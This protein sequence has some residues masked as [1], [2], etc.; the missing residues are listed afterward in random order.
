MR[1]A[2]AWAAG[3]VALVR[4][5]L[6]A[7]SAAV[8]GLPSAKRRSGRSVTSQLPSPSAAREA[9]SCGTTGSPPPP[10]P[11]PPPPGQP[12]TVHDLAAITGGTLNPRTL[13]L[14]AAAP[15][16]GQG[17]SSFWAWLRGLWPIAIVLALLLFWL[18]IKIR[19]GTTWEDVKNAFP[20]AMRLLKETGNKIMPQR[21]RKARSS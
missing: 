20:V 3:L 1:P 19:N 9:A 14:P 8:T 2:D 21:R 15:E 17:A 18:E 7:T 6:A 5:R 10:P 13:D 11:P 4:P 16:R 12:A